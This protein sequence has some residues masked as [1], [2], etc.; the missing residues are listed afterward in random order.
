M[1]PDPAARFDD[2][3][4]PIESTATAWLA[5]RD[6]GLT[7]EETVAFA[8]W[9][10]ADPRHEA[11]VTELGAMWHA[12]D[13]LSAL[14]G[15]ALSPP[16]SLAPT[17]ASDDDRVAPSRQRS[18]R[19]M[20][21]IAA[22]I[23]LLA[24]IVTWQRSAPTAISAEH[25]ATAVGAQRTI[26][27]P[28]GSTLQLNTN[29]AAD[30]RYDAR[31]RHVELVRGE[32]FFTVTKDAQRPFVVRSSG[33]EA[34]ALGTAFV[35]RQRETETELVVT[36]G[37]VKF[38]ASAHPAAAVEV[39]AGNLSLCDPRTSDAPRV[40]PLDKAGLARRLAW[41]SGRL[42]CRPGMPLA[43]AAAEFNRYHRQQLMLRDAETAA[44]PI[45]GAFELQNLEAFVRTLENSSE[46]VVVE[47]DAGR[48]VLQSKR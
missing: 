16:A 48:I 39:T 46:S 3:L 11:A 15:Q 23:A 33:V 17:F 36:E 13:D 29:S 34:R 12:L 4:D 47:R 32:V 37:R 8:Q 25:Y 20:W 43:D 5:R 19:W 26:T 1:N 28:D 21:A 10:S 42:V 41:Q 31:E 18:T 14:R 6:R 9:R 24:G 22:G 2:D 45:G 30:V 27:L 44:V 7:T 35:V 40:S 38:H